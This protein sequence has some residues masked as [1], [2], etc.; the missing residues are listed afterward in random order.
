MGEMDEEDTARG[1]SVYEYSHAHPMPL[2][3][4]SPITTNLAP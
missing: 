2:M 3:L 1:M 4:S